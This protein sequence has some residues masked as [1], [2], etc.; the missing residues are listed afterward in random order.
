MENLFTQKEWIQIGVAL[1]AGG[2]MGSILKAVFDTYQNRVRTIVYKMTVDL[3]SCFDEGLP[4]QPISYEIGGKKQSRSFDRYS[5]ANFEIQNTTGKDIAELTFGITLFGG[6][7]AFRVDTISPDRH[8]LC[9]TVD[10]VST[11]S[12]KSTIDFVC[13]P[14]NRKDIYIMKLFISRGLEEKAINYPRLS[15]ALPIRFLDSEVRASLAMTIGMREARKAGISHAMDTVDVDERIVQTN[16]AGK[17]YLS[18]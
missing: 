11:T 2:A 16:E 15:S 9:D 7:V 13:K 1:I 4:K 5:I 10:N 8:H 18:Y 12:A 14:F 6:D 17:K 3:K